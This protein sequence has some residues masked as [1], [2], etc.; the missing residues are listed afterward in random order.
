MPRLFRDSDRLD[1]E[2]VWLILETL[3]RPGHIDHRINNN[4]G[5]MNALWSKLPR[6]GLGQ[7]ALRCLGRS[8][9]RE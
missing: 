5:D 8:E 4:V 9:A 2:L 3:A 1:E 6:Y 7:N